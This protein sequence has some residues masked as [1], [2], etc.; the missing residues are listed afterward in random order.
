[1]P[2]AKRRLEQSCDKDE[3]VGHR[4]K[5]P[6][7]RW[8]LD[9]DRVRNNYSTELLIDQPDRI[10]PGSSTGGSLIPSRAASGSSGNT[11]QELTVATKYPASS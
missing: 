8:A 9:G 11:S 3:T 6:R 1:M 2:G 10:T 7:G 4:C 5:N